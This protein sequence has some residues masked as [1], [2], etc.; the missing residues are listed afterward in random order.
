MYNA[1]DRCSVLKRRFDIDLDPH[2]NI[3]LSYSGATINH[4]RIAAESAVEK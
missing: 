2:A 4:R 3:L 1:A